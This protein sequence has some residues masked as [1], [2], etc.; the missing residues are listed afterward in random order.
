MRVEFA[1]IWGEL[2][3]GSVEQTLNTLLAAE[4]DRLCQA[5]RYERSPDRNDRRAG[6]YRR[7][8]QTKAGTVTLEVP[9]LRRVQSALMLVAARLRHIAGTKWGT[10]AYMAM[11]SLLAKSAPRKAA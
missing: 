9:K 7:K 5:S 2:V 1:T 10:R 4:P 6:H 11:E 8:L 3:R